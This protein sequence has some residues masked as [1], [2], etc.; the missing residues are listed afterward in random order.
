M[1]S[2]TVS[3]GSAEATVTPD[4]VAAEIIDE[5]MYVPFGFITGAEQRSKP[6]AQRELYQLGREWATAFCHRDGEAVLAL[7]LD[8]ESFLKS[9]GSIVNGVPV[10]GISSPWPW[11]AEEARVIVGDDELSVVLRFRTSASVSSHRYALS[12]VQSG[13]GL[14]I[15]GV[16]EPHPDASSRAAFYYNY[17]YGL[18][19]FSTASL[20]GDFDN[21]I[22]SVSELLRIENENAI[23]TVTEEQTDGSVKITY[24][25]DD[26]SVTVIAERSELAVSDGRGLWVPVGIDEPLPQVRLSNYEPSQGQAIGFQLLSPRSGA[27][28]RLTEGAGS[29]VPFGSGGRLNALIPVAPSAEAGLHELLVMETR[30]G[31]EEIISRLEY[32]VQPVVFTR[33]DLRVSQTTASVLTDE[34]IQSDNAKVRAAKS[35]TAPQPL[36]DGLFGQPVRGRQRIT[37]DFGQLR[38]TNGVYTSRHSAFDIA[39]S[40]G[41]D[42]EATAGGVVVLAEPLFVSGNAV[43][44]DHGMWLFTSYYHL[45]EIKVSVGDEVAAGDVIGTVGSTGYSTGAHLHYA[46]S[47]KGQG[48]NPNMLKRHNPLS[49]EED[50]R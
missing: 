38:Y 50:Y 11:F 8:E 13:D 40:L 3:V 7:F 32:N 9:G 23:N 49:F 25:W 1:R 16:T 33:Q 29:I 18:P 28:Y 20:D 30:N 17:E 12:Y 46:A 35:A 41:T 21:A 34:H 44:I 45:N 19:P 5:V 43:I 39:A 22:K 14:K 4:G 24:T 26:G 37:T 2:A 36:W 15:T 27:S 42:V 47:V 10:I 6:A 48:V 31:R